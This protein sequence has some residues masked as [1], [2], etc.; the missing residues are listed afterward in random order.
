MRKIAFLLAAGFAIGACAANSGEPQVDATA[1]TAV[2]GEKAY[3]EHCAGCHETGLLGA[4]REGEP[5]DWEGRSNLWQA[6]LMD[7]AKTGYFD[8]PARGGKS[9]LP[10]EVVHAAA[11][12]MLEI[13]F[14]DR[15]ED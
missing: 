7:H 13:T 4:P 14:P 3:I 1:S 2:D 5:N 9:E 10:D 15:P 11:E 12:Y 6:V 8:M